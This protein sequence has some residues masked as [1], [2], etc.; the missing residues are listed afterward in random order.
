MFMCVDIY[1]YSDHTHP[2]TQ[3]HTCTLKQGQEAQLGSGQDD[4]WEA[5]TEELES[6]LAREQGEVC[7]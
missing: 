6:K 5:R 3:T 7:L 1:K 2:Y 4:L